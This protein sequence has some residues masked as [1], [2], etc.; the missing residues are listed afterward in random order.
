MEG[1]VVSTIFLAIAI[2][3]DYLHTAQVSP[4]SSAVPIFVF[5]L[6]YMANETC[7]ERNEGTSLLK[8]TWQ[9]LT[10]K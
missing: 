8:L 7:K 6:L 10:K 3:T 9:K 2:A 4:V 5:Q 1:I